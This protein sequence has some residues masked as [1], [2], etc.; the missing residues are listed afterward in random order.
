LTWLREGLRLRRSKPDAVVIVWWVWIWALPYLVLIAWLPR[1]LPVLV[2]CH[3]VSDKEPKWWKSWMA[4]LLFRRADALVVHSATGEAELVERLGEKIRPRIVRLYL[5]LLAIGRGMPSRESAKAIFGL[6]GQ[7][8]V[9]F[10][11]HIRPFKGLDVALRAWPGVDPGI[12][13]LA[14][15]EV[16]WSSE[17][18]IRRAAQG[19]G[20]ID[21]VAFRFG[22]VPDAEVAECFAAADVIIAPYRHEAQSGVAMNAFHFGRAVIASAV[23]GIPEVIVPE[24]NGDLVPPDDP[25]SLARS[26]NAFFR[27]GKQER[28][29][30]GVRESAKKYSWSGY[31]TAVADAIEKLMETRV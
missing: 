15:G 17:S 18:E 5:P 10:F 4:N 30:A 29:E 7:K 21:R 3:N 12:V 2:Q 8:V 16:W 22:Y 13:L 6:E 9:L 26:I 23:G 1:K 14:V 25:A 27:E 24:V 19:L 28:L 31:G 20:V 11:G